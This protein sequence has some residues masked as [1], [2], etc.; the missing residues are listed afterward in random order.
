MTFKNLLATT[1]FLS[2]SLHAENSIGIDIN[3]N[4]VEVL[5][6]INL[7]SLADYGNGT[8]YVLDVN[9]LHSDGDN[10]THV[11]FLGQNTLQGVEGLILSFGLKSVIADDFLAFPLMAKA[12]YALPLVGSVP[13]TSL[14]LSVAYAPSVLSLRNAESYSDFRL[15]ADMEVI[16]NIHLFTG[17]RNIKT[18]YEDYDQTFNNSFYGGLRL[19][20]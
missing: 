11:G 13:P 10:M 3:S 6:S 18:N 9:Y 7:N 12:L 17:Y 20:F 2:T 15:E 8:T 4:D 14:A 5:A 1:L 19:S 16:S